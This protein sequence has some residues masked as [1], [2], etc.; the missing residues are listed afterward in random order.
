MPLERALGPILEAELLRRHEAHGVRFYCGESLFGVV[1]DTNVERVILTGGVTLECDVLVVAV[2]SDPQTAW[3]QDS[4]LDITDGVL[5]DAGLRAMT[6]E[7]D[8]DPR[9]VAVGDVARYVNPLFDSI[10]R[11]VEHWNLPTETGKRA[12]QILA[13]QLAGG[14]AD[15]LAEMPFAPLPSFWSDQYDANLLAF[16]MTHLADRSELV[17]GTPDTEC[18]VEYF[19][20]DDLVGVCG[21]GMRGAV[22][23]YRSR[24]VMS[25]A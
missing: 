13:V 18:V 25:V 17:A 9:V 21:I 19:R 12:G 4:G 11:R 15:A 2:G 10:P 7:G 20:R 6:A 16:G 3:L 1:G 5:V 23:S 8:V 14:D 24:F 22:Q